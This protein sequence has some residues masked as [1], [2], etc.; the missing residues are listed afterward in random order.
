A[1]G[2]PGLV[3]ALEMVKSSFN[4]YPIDR[5]AQAAALAAIED[6]AWLDDTRQR[7][8]AAREALA[9]GLRELDFE[10]LPSATNFLF[11]RHRRVPGRP[12][13]DGV[14]REGVLVRRFD[15]PRI[16]EFLRISIGTPAQCE[17]LRDTLARLLD[18]P[19]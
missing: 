3:A 5:L 15:A 12:L 8:M 11:A 16:D 9:D 10:V 2:D 1:M 7:V 14:R 18:G 17:R 6:E 4:S 19:G 13:F